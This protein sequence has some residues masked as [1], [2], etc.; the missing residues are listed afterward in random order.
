MASGD[1]TVEGPFMKAE[2]G[3][4]EGVGGA[5]EETAVTTGALVVLP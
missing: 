5:G 2:K 3:L 1:M 4:V